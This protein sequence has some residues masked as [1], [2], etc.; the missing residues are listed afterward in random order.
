MMRVASL[1]L[2]ALLSA[3]AGQSTETSYYLLR[4]DQGLTSR[5]LV[6]STHYVLDQITIAPYLNQGGLILETQAGEMRTARHHLWA[7]PLY[8][9]IRVFLMTE[10]SQAKGEDIL[11]GKIEEI[12]TSINVRIDQ[13]HGTHDGR[14]R[15]VAYW[16][17]Q[18]GSDIEAA[19][20]FAEYRDLGE[21]G[22]DA[23]ARAEKALL[24]DLAGK[25]AATL[26]A[27]DS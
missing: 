15:L 10:I 20:Q 5:T 3:C 8:E 27:T 2:V 24:S 4:S 26:V 19:Y 1:L 21:D 12:G 18:K 6:P 22:Y 23:L 11:M 7:E 16:W 13:L 25:I 9:G 17:L 14:A